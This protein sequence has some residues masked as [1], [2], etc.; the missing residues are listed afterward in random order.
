MYLCGS[1][2][3]V[4]ASVF[5]HSAVMRVQSIPNSYIFYI[6]NDRKCRC[7]LLLNALQYLLLE[8]VGVTTQ[9]IKT[10][11]IIIQDCDS[12]YTGNILTRLPSLAWS[13]GSRVKLALNISAS[14]GI[15]SFTMDTLKEI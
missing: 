9:Y 6:F 1:S 15:L 11:T 8:N 3:N 5:S 7:S 13:A 2:Y 12:S 10:L 4:V 14:S